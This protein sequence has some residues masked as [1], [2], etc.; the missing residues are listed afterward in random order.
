MSSVPRNNRFRLQIN[1]VEISRISK[2]TALSRL[3]GMIVHLFINL[4]VDKCNIRWKFNGKYNNFS[5]ELS[6]DAF[7]PTC[8]PISHE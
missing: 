5:Y 6:N 3:P 7:R 2:L 1:V 4:K 8:N